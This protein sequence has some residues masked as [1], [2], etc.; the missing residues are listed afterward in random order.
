[1]INPQGRKATGRAEVEKL[2]AEEH[3]A[4]YKGSHISFAAGKFRFL[5]PDVAVFTTDFI[6]PD[7]HTPD[8]TEVNVN[9][10][11]TSVMIR[12]EGKWVTAAARPM[13]PPP[14]PPGQ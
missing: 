3:S 5:K 1:M 2:F 12:K 10:I 6:V 7:A 4:N 14:P 11:V 13:I 9:G 8:G